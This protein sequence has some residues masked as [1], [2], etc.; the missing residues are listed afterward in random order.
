M[1]NNNG[2]IG[3]EDRVIEDFKS[4]DDTSTGAGK[5]MTNKLEMKMM[6]SLMLRNDA[7]F[8]FDLVQQFD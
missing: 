5:I 2:K 4:A 3:R 6:K 8:R 7:I 1:G